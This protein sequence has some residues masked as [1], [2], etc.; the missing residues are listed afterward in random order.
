MGITLTPLTS[1]IDARRKI[2]SM[3]IKK[4]RG[5]ERR[6]KRLNSFVGLLKPF[7]M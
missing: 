6:W 7:G 5:Y 1:Y 4:V 3:G 2:L